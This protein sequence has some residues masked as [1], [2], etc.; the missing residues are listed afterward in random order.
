MGEEYRL[1]PVDQIS[2]IGNIRKTFDQQSLDELAESIKTYGILQP[3]VVRTLEGQ[4]GTVYALVA[5]ERRLRA[6]KQAGLAEVPC[7][8]VSLTAKQAAEVQLLENLQRQDLN[9]IEEAQALS[10]LMKEHGYTQEAL[11]SKLG[12]SQPWVASRTRLLNL[13][14]SVQNGITR[15]IINAS[16]GE[17]LA[18]YAKTAPSLVVQVV[19]KMKDKP[20]PVARLRDEIDYEIRKK[21]QPL[22]DSQ[23]WA[24]PSFDVQPC[25]ESC[26]NVVYLRDYG[27]KNERPFCSE[28]ACWTE[29][30]TE[31]KEAARQAVISQ[32]GNAAV[33]LDALG[34]SNW[35]PL[36]DDL[37]ALIECPDDCAWR[38][39]GVR[40]TR[41]GAETLDVCIKPQ[42]L[43][44]RRNKAHEARETAKKQKEKEAMLRYVAKCDSLG[45]AV[46]LGSLPPRLLVSVAASLLIE[47]LI[48]WYDKESLSRFVKQIGWKGSLEPHVVRTNERIEFMKTLERLPGP[49]L[50]RVIL[51]RMIARGVHRRE[52]QV[53]YLLGEAVEAVEAESA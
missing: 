49:F 21:C 20:I 15:G 25:L 26:P 5:G 11:A 30:D 39:Q 47:I 16:A 52:D 7:R 35:H 41:G 36:V 46:A 3:L 48:E 38:V 33:D 8:V 4:Y 22:D 45:Y 50:A 23:S 19:E 53:R 13:P 31:A 24:M 9:P 27:S 28:P 12:K 40:A 2:V 51:D 32:A 14:E 17:I 6:A 1:L 37:L 34:W 29:R 18:R 44:D 10:D 43:A 42:C